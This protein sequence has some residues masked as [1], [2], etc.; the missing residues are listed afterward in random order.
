MA[1]FIGIA[2]L[3]IQMLLYNVKSSIC[4]DNRFYV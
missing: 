2:V 3:L 1:V 4:N